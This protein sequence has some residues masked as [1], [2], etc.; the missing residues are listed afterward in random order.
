[1]SFGFPSGHAQNA[2]TAWIATAFYFKKRWIWTT[3]ILLISLVGLSRVYLGV[4]FP[5]DVLGGWVIGA[6]F[7]CLWLLMESRFGPNWQSQAIPR[8]LFVVGI[9]LALTLGVSFLIFRSNPVEP[10]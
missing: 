8:K 1:T 10:A 5:T 4:H 2:A 7:A 3:A 6:L 9:G